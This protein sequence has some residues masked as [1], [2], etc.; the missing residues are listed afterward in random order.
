[1]LCRIYPYLV[2]AT[3]ARRQMAAA[4]RRRLRAAG[5]WSI[6]D[7]SAAER[8]LPL[9]LPLP[10][11]AAD[12][13]AAVQQQRVEHEV[14]LGPRR[15]RSASAMVPT[16]AA[17]VG[18]NSRWAPRSRTSRAMPFCLSTHCT[19]WRESRRAVQ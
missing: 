3:T 11:P 9:L 16:R 6:G 4:H 19:R 5:Q 12:V 15:W 8:P 1:M 17:V 10:Q 14:E 13:D 7:G 2:R 18:V